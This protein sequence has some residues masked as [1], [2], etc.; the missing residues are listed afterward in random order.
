MKFDGL[1]ELHYS[2]IKF[3]FDGQS[4]A[5]DLCCGDIWKSAPS[6]SKA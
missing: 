2:R 6:L 1:R 3:G 5:I 4:A